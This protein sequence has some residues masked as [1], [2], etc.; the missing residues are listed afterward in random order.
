VVSEKKKKRKE[1]YSNIEYWDRKP[2]KKII[3]KK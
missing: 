2:F 3:I 1:R